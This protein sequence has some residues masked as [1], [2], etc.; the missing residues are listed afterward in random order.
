MPRGRPRKVAEP[1]NL[2]NEDVKLMQEQTQE[3]KQI[4]GKIVDEWY[5][6]THGKYLHK[7]RF[8]NGN[9]YSTFIGRESGVDKDLV[10]KWIK[11]GLLRAS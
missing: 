3:H 6:K 2:A 11:D 1:V 4:K 10:R 7:K 8:K 5:E 9:V